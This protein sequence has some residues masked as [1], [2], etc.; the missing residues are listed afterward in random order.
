MYI[1]NDSICDP[2]CDFCWY[3]IH[4][5]SGEPILC[6]K[7][8]SNFGEGIGYCEKFKCIVHE[9]KPDEENHEVNEIK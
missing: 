5:K 2:C 1:C 7:N 9:L 4:G 6:E 8:G 3:C